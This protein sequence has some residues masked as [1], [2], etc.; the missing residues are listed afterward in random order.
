MSVQTCFLTETCILE[1]R[2]LIEQEVGVHAERR[3][4]ALVPTGLS[5][6][7]ML[8]KEGV[9]PTSAFCGSALYGTG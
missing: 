1:E 9:V 4:R 8:R 3:G 5:S 7:T 6:W 2:A